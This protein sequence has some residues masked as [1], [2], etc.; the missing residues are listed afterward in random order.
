M[1]PLS[2]TLLIKISWR[3]KP[4]G[5]WSMGSQRSE[6]TEEAEHTHVHTHTRAHTHTTSGTMNVLY[7]LLMTL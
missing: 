6:M 3:E 5:L 2:V 1:E 4:H 7:L